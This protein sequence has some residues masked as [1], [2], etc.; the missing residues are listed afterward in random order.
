MIVDACTT[1]FKQL[2]FCMYIENYSR[3]ELDGQLCLSNNFEKRQLPFL[4]VDHYYYDESSIQDKIMIWEH[5]LDEMM[6]SLD[7]FTTV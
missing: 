3:A 4:T 6:M 7:I 2:G 1:I 5:D